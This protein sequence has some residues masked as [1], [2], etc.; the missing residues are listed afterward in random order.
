MSQ[1][2]TCD[3]AII[4]Q[5][6]IWTKQMSLWLSVPCESLSTYALIAMLRDLVN[7]NFKTKLN[8]L[9]CVHFYKVV[10]TLRFLV[11]EAIRVKWNFSKRLK[12][13]SYAIR[14][15][16]VVIDDIGCEFY[17]DQTCSVFLFNKFVD[18]LRIDNGISVR[19]RVIPGCVSF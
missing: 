15:W 13:D 4:G 6:S 14:F 7:P 17:G 1:I 5:L 11:V 12:Y 10:S 18:V 8:E 3:I 16:C 9:S 19:L 2:G